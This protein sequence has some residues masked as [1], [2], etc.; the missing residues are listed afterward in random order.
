MNFTDSMYRNIN[1]TKFSYFIFFSFNNN[2]ETRYTKSCV[3]LKR[4]KISII[5]HIFIISFLLFLHWRK[6]IFRDII[7][8]YLY[9]ISHWAHYWKSFH[10]KVARFVKNKSSISF[11]YSLT[12]TSI[13]VPDDIWKSTT[14]I[15]NF[16]VSH[17]VSPIFVSRA[18]WSR[19][20]YDRYLVWF[21]HVSINSDTRLL[22]LDKT[23][24]FL[25]IRYSGQSV[26]SC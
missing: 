8:Q 7:Y 25:V 20:H 19:I 26:E 18:I 15:D 3:S 13:T 12:R 24:S 4:N 21:Y 9:N 1:K 11:F 5:V 6:K 14:C 22:Y 16:R 17:I 10:T 23:I 2:L